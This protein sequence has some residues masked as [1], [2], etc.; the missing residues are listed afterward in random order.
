VGTMDGL[1]I[2]A[3]TDEYHLEENK[4]ATRLDAGWR[5]A[6]NM[7]HQVTAYCASST[8]VFKFP[9]MRARVTGLRIKAGN[10]ESVIPIEEERDINYV[11]HWANWLRHTVDQ[12][13]Q[14]IDNYEFAPRYTHS[15][16]R[17]YR[18]CSLLPFCCDTP[19]GRRIA[20]EKEMI[21][22]DASPSERAVIDA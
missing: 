10:G 1:T 4:T 9:I 14:W 2:K 7:A 5:G 13:E 15:C 16:N 19:E 22:A 3:A 21:E 17:Y 11:L 8:S 18:P 20:Y 12:Y 6:F